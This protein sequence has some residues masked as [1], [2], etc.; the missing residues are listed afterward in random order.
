[1]KHFKL[2]V[3]TALYL[4][5]FTASGLCQEAKKDDYLVG[6]D[7]VMEI[8]VL[9]PEKMLTT[10]TVAPGGSITFPYIG[11]VMVKGM[12]L[13]AIQDE[14]QRR[15]AD[16]YMKY[17]VVSVSLKEARSKKFFVYGEVARPGTYILED[18]T[19]VLKAISIAGGFSKFGSS[20]RVRVLRPKEDASVYE[21]I[22]VNIKAIMNGSSVEDLK[23]QPG[24]I[25]N[26]AEGI[27]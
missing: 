14:I 10:V 17:P 24:D 11:N 21:N 16:G 25:V 23:L 3:I 1:M 6:V 27:F 19:T 2:L 9:Q 5:S 15:L 8:A 12:T 4:F 26:V 22:K 18:G 7:D 20:S 13:G